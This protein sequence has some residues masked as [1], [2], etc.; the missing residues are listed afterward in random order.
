[1]KLK[2]PEQ[3]TNINFSITE[4]TNNT[5]KYLAVE[6]PNPTGK[7]RCFMYHSEIEASLPND[8]ASTWTQ[9]VA[10]IFVGNQA[11]TSVLLSAADCVQSEKIVKYCGAGAAPV[12]LT[13]DGPEEVSSPCE[14]PRQAKD[15]KFY[16]T[17]AVK[18][19]NNSSATAAYFH[20]RF[21]MTD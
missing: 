16:I 9:S 2:M 21:R 18:G 7:S 17:G 10:S 19:W 6:V 4:D 8:V 5:I 12:L 1:V 3:L 20:C 11:P 14:I 13:V 15:G